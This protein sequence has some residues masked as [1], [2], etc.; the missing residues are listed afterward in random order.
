M[1][2]IKDYISDS[3]RVVSVS[4]GNH[5]LSSITG[6]GCMATACVAAFAAVEEP[7]VATIG[8]Y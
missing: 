3:T 4:N 7:F 2:G 1:T 6:S 5:W 8:G